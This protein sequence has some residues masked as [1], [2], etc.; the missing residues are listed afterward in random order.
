MSRTLDQVNHEYTNTLT[1]AG[2][3]TYRARLLQLEAEG[4]YKQA[5]KLNIEAGEFKKKDLA[6][7]TTP[8]EQKLDNTQEIA[9]AVE[10]VEQ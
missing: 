5:D 4:L 10:L 1:L 6:A 7:N 9:D 3:K 2:D 8:T